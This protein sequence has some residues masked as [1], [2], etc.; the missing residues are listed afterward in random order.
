MGVGGNGFA[1]RKPLG[2]KDFLGQ[3]RSH[4]SRFLTIYLVIINLIRISKNNL[5]RS[6]KS[7]TL[8]QTTIT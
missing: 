7:K 5:L 1:P 4:Q 8:S 2:S 3:I 6:V